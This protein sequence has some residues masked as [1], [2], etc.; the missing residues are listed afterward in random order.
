MKKRAPTTEKSAFM[1]AVNRNRFCIYSFFIAAAIM[2]FVYIVYKFIP[3]GEMSILR[4][5]L[6]HQ[7]GPL[8]AEFYERVTN[9]DSLIYSWT[10]GLGGSFTGNYL[11]YLASPLGDLI[12]LLSGHDNMPEAIAVMV[13]IKAALAAAT[14]TYFINNYFNRRD[15][16]SCAFSVLYA[17]CGFFVAYYWNIMW[18]NGMVLFP[19]IVLGI[20]KIIEGKTPWLYLVTLTMTMLSSYYM[21]YMICLLSVIWFLVY[22]F[23]KYDF[24]SVMHEYDLKLTRREYNSLSGSDK[25][26]LTRRNLV[27]NRFLYAGV[28]FAGSSFL[29]FG[30]SAAALIPLYFILTSC[31]ATGN[32]FPSDYKSYFTIFDFLANHLAGVT[33][34]IRSSGEDVLPNI[35]SGVLPLLLLPIY[36]F[37]KKISF[38]EKVASVCLLAIFYFS[39]NINYLN[40][41]WHGFHFPNDLPY[42]FSFAYSFF[43]L[44]MA[45]KAFTI[46]DSVSSKALIG[47]GVAVIGFTILVQEIG[48]KNVM[49]DNDGISVASD[50]VI[51]AT[52]VFA[53]I[54]CVV[55]AL[56]KNPKYFSSAMCALL[57]CC[58][59]T[60]IIVVDTQNYEFQQEKQWF[61]ED[62]ADYEPLKAQIDEKELAENPNADGFYRMELSQL[63]ARMDSC[64]FYYNG[65]STFSSMAY[66]SVA[67]M[68]KDIGMFG[69]DVNSYTY[70]PQTP[71]FNT[72][73]GL[74]YV[75]D[76]SERISDNKYYTSVASN[77]TYTVY[78][79]QYQMPLAFCVNES[80]ADWVTNGENPFDDQA[81]MWN[82]ATGTAGVFRDV[83]I[84]VESLDNLSDISDAA[85]STGNFTISKIS[86]GV[87]ASA[88][89]TLTAPA[90]GN[91]YLYTQSADC[92]VALVSSPTVSKD[93]TM[94]SPYLM[95]CGYLNAGETVSVELQMPNDKDSATI[96]LYAVSCDNEVFEA[97]YNNLLANGVLEYT[98]FDES[99]FSGTITAAANQILYTSI[100]YDEGW[101]V[102]IDDVKM[103]PADY[104]QIGGALLAVPISAGEHTVRFEYSPRGLGIGVVLMVIS[105]LILVAI[106]IMKK[107][108]VLLFSEKAI[109]AVTLKNFEPTIRL[110][111]T[112]VPTDG[113][114][115]ADDF[116]ADIPPQAPDAV[117]S[118]PASET[119]EKTPGSPSTD[120]EQS[121]SSDSK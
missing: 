50:I 85:V 98:S 66:E 41:I 32:S 113:N 99:R 112:V 82:L 8:F 94:D 43:L 120:P 118:Q 34:T 102:Y 115:P 35:Y 104:I 106:V 38:R 51:W 62:Y 119:P 80:L 16:S 101:S 37:S 84:Q 56:I 11:N 93:I 90:D 83:D 114:A 24:E 91:L 17:F 26:K 39:F 95:D 55:L 33:P 107:K 92:D 47:S 60:E 48:S 2:L 65:V 73:F 21:A 22:F 36:L 30:L 63:K 121:Q 74:S 111:E 40:F 27:N 9:L 96:R 18:L 110:P 53:V 88:T 116:T 72:M 44:F 52:I 87:F 67:K 1:K 25:S 79:Y 59:V 6:Y 69:N 64:W 117:P 42:R 23:G 105:L 5:D 58:T 76:N 15:V 81:A 89:L 13:L 49:V 108:K 75:F 57:L 78:E 54:Y 12:M 20:V 46:L 28:K 45:Y 77:D 100:P 10:S 4:M 103:D 19:L 31:S 86:S 29:A 14:F 70:Y 68:M 7:Y 3:F 61:V 71:I 109:N 97:G